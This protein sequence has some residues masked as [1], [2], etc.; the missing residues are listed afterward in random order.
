MCL[1]AA[2]RG[3]CFHTVKQRSGGVVTQGPVVS[4]AEYA[5]F[6]DI[7]KNKIVLMFIAKFSLKRYPLRTF[8]NM[9]GVLCSPVQHISS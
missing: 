5:D 3:R 1:R 7:F 8:T 4:A 6:K 2:G 9:S